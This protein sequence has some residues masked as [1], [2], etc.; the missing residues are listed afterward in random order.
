ML[1]SALTTIAILGITLLALGWR[2]KRVSDDPHCANCRFDLSGLPDPIHDHR[3]PE[4]GAGLGGPSRITHGR[5]ARRPGR[6]A[7]GTL[8][9]LASLVFHPW[10]R[11]ITGGASHRWR[12]FPILLFE[13][14]LAPGTPTSGALD[15]IQRRAVAGTLTP[16]QWSGLAAA[17][18]EV[19]AETQAR[20]DPTWGDLFTLADAGGHATDE[21]VTQYA[22]VAVDGFTFPRRLAWIVDPDADVVLRNYPQPWRGA[23]G[24]PDNRRLAQEQHNE[25]LL[26]FELIDASIDGKPVALWDWTAHF[27]R[28]YGQGHASDSLDYFQ[29]GATE[30][31]HGDAPPPAGA[32]ERRLYAPKDHRNGLTLASPSRAGVVL[33][34]LP[35]GTY[36]L[37]VTW[38]V[39]IVR[40]TT[41]T[42]A[43]SVDLTHNC[44]LSVHGTYADLYR[45]TDDPSLAGA[46]AEFWEGTE[47]RFTDSTAPGAAVVGRFAAR[48][49]ES[50]FPHAFAVAMVLRAPDGTEVG[51]RSHFGPPWLLSTTASKTHNRGS[52]SFPGYIKED[53]LPALVRF[54][55]E[56]TLVLRFDPRVACSF[57]ARDIE[58]GGP[59]PVFWT[60][61]VVVGPIKIPERL[62]TVSRP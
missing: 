19:Q 34:E 8:L 41:V 1:V 15:E 20:W 25:P 13:A 26:V 55:D 39:H 43:G 16:A 36:A 47:L 62:R 27:D 51:V 29:V 60:R 58:D 6:I 35:P 14:R 5:R 21:Q 50:D 22:S 38:R 54:G 33:D 31:T 3:C 24:L 23:N 7:L 18:L 12:P 56:A 37:G 52:H 61:D 40:A 28:T 46:A 49:W 30:T 45:T 44:T 42:T 57:V 10:A 48:A 4:C 53:D 17:A 11:A 32:R 2:G 9:I 59:R